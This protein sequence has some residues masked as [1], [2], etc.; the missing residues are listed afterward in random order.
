MSTKRYETPRDP[1]LKD[2]TLRRRPIPVAMVAVEA[3]LLFSLE[4]EYGGSHS[5]GSPILPWQA[6][7]IGSSWGPDKQKSTIVN[8]SHSGQSMIR[9]WGASLK[10]WVRWVRRPA[11][12]H[13]HGSRGFFMLIGFLNS[14]Q[15]SARNA[16]VTCLA[17]AVQ[18]GFG[19]KRSDNE[20]LPRGQCWQ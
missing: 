14:D 11:F 15:A 2:R 12:F 16:Y 5:F 4:Y 13:R 1:S 6:E 17:R 8:L 7:K 19:D 18:A 20:D 9:K 10:K 3:K